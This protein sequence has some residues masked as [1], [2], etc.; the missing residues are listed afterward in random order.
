[1]VEIAKALSL[2]TSIIVMD[3]PSATLTEKEMNCLFGIINKLKQKGVTIIYISH[4]LEE[5]F[6]ISDRVTVLRDGELIKCVDTASI[7]KAKLICL[8]IGRELDKS[9][10]IRDNCVQD[11]CLLA[12]RNLSDENLLKDA[13]FK[14]RKGEMLGISGL[15]GSG[16]TELVRTIF[17]FP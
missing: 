9:F 1:M 14:L 2:N 17:C 4:R 10:P 12:V 13:S 15:V 11:S 6:K 7:D 8:M 16:R 3:E 5:L